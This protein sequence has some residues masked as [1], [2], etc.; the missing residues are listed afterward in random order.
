MSS[1]VIPWLPLSRLPSMGGA[2][3]ACGLVGSPD[4]SLNVYP[5]ILRGVR[6]IGIDSANCSGDTRDKVWRKLSN[7]WKPKHLEEMITEVDLNGLEEKIQ[8]ILRGESRG[9][10]VVRLP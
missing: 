10:V 4:L 3:T 2:V 7:E 6:L 5:F 9:R 8:S 1:E